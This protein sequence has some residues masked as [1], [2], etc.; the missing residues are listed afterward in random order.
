MRSIGEAIGVQFSEN[1]NIFRVLARTGKGMRKVSVEGE[2]G[3]RGNIEHVSSLAHPCSSFLSKAISTLLSLFLSPLSPS[4]N[5]SSSPPPP[6]LHHT[7]LFIS[8]MTILNKPKNLYAG[9]SIFETSTHR[10]IYHT[11]QTLSLIQHTKIA[12]EHW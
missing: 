4:H 3:S 11:H 6:L 9:F 5:P 2:G 8:N 12:L 10:T 7:F 1:N